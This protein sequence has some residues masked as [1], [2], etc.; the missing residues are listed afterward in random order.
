MSI[1]PNPHAPHAD[2]IIAPR[3]FAGGVFLYPRRLRLSTMITPELLEILRCPMDPSN[4]KLEVQDNN[5]V[6]THC[7]VVFPSRDG[8]PALLIEEAQLPPG[9]TTI[10]QLPCQRKTS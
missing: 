1:P 9:C 7:R 10:E 3:R 5:L 6:C 2:L 4:T 8:F